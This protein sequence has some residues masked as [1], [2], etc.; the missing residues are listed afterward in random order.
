MISYN[1]SD[2]VQCL[3]QYDMFAN[4]LNL[5]R[6]TDERSM[7]VKQLTKLEEKIIT[8]TNAEYEEEYYELMGKECGLLEEEK[9][10]IAALIELINQRLSY[11][12][13][14]CNN[15]YQLT[16]ES[17]DVNDVLGASELDEL[18][19]KLKIIDKY[20]ENVRQ[21]ALLE[22]DIKSLTSKISL[23]S[24]KIDINKSLNLELE[25]TFKK[26]LNDAFSKLGLYELLDN[27][28]NIEYDYY[29]TEK[30]L[31]LAQ[32]NYET[33][34]NSHLDILA[35]C[36]EMLSDISKDYTKYKDQI[37]ILK[38]I[39]IYE[40]DVNDYN[41]LLAKRREVND[42]LKGIKNEELLDLISDTVSKQYNTIMM[43]EQDINTFNDLALE[44][45]RKLETL[46]EIRDENNSEEF[47]SVLKVLIE[48]EKKKQEKLLEEQRKIEEEEKKRRQEIERKKQEEILKKQ[49]IIEEARKKEIEKR[50]KKLLEEQQNSVLQGRK[51]D[52]N[53]SFETI[54][55]VS[56]ENEQNDEHEEMVQE[57]PVM[58]RE[59]RN[60]KMK[61]NDLNNKDD[62]NEEQELK[63]KNDEFLFKNKVDIEKELFEEFNNKN[64]NTIT[65]HDDND[66]A[67]VS[68]NENKDDDSD[69]DLNNISLFGDKVEEEDKGNSL[70]NKI[71]NKMSN[72]SFPD[73]SIDEYMKNF[74]EDKLEK[75]DTLSDF[76]DEF[77]TIPM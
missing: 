28:N 20:S 18:E 43:E 61:L 9:N 39:D 26:I 69:N 53:V 38:L 51:K 47:Q 57:K 4:S 48:N 31:T 73:M 42:I 62:D 16:G 35:D 6:S 29:E 58:S 36:Q 56:L 24:E 66:D 71:E 5:I 40:N 3:R 65:H 2:V 46:S 72:N 33:A 8:L 25:T 52:N 12:E 59:E 27:R 10:R 23:A 37:N 55:D 22:E 1:N 7:I 19:N 21:E 17:I 68:K 45:E 14:R 70:L 67:V 63:L 76:G 74:D 15:H 77:P 30:L 32:L 34:K 44:K 13:K 64:V 54:K 11:V 41:E 49:K 75:S 50:T 60:H